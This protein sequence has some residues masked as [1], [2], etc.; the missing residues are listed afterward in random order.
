M[1]V[2][3][4]A[5]CLCGAL[6][7]ATRAVT[8]IYDDALR[9]SG[10]RITQLALLR[11]LSRRGEL[12]MH[13]LSAVLVVEDT[14]LNRSA[15]AMQD[16]G[17]IEIRTGSDRRE[18]M[19]SITAAGRAVLAEAEPLWAEAQRRMTDELGKNFD[20]LVRSLAEV[21]RSAAP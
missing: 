18:R 10:L 3:G 14:T 17:W 9:P 8:R 16:R 5:P 2:N 6:R 21:T 1:D 15:R 13:D 20:A 12:R 11:Q 7:K 19:V 4:T